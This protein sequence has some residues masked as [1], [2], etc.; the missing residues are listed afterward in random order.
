MDKL[1]N[2]MEKKQ[3]DFLIIIPDDLSTD[4][5]RKVEETKTQNYIEFAHYKKLIQN[6]PKHT[7]YIKHEI[8]NEHVDKKQFTIY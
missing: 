3:R 7:S 4:V 5:L 1:Y 2:L 6:I 8:T